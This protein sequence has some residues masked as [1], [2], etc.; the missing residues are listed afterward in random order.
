MATKGLSVFL[1]GDYCPLIQPSEDTAAEAADGASASAGAAAAVAR[2]FDWSA[3]HVHSSQATG[4]SE[5][6]QQPESSVEI[7][8]AGP[9]VKARTASLLLPRHVLPPHAPTYVCISTHNRYTPRVGDIVI[10]IVNTKG[11]EYYGVRTPFC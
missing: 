3:V 1:P 2:T 7:E 11:S 4:T 10:G 8:G 9:C 5:P 6:Q